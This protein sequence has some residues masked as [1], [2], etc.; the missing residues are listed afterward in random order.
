MA[1]ADTISRIAI[2]IG[3]WEYNEASSLFQEARALRNEQR[4]ILKRDGGYSEE[5]L[6]RLKNEPRTSGVI[7]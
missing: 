3:R 6:E 2:I 1:A 4:E 5:D 7:G